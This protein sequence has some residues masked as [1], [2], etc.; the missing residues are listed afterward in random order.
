MS[1]LDED[2]DPIRGEH[3]SPQINSWRNGQIHTSGSPGYLKMAQKAQNSASSASIRNV[4]PIY[5]DLRNDVPSNVHGS[6]NTNK[7]E[8]SSKQPHF[9]MNSAAYGPPVNRP[10]NSAWSDRVPPNVVPRKST[11][12]SA[13]AGP[14]KPT[15]YASS[16]ITTGQSLV[17]DPHRG[18]SSK[19]PERQ[20]SS[21]QPVKASSLK[22]SPPHLRDLQTS[23]AASSAD[24]IDDIR[25]ETAKMNAGAASKSAKSDSKFPCTY[26]ECTRGF[27][28]KK[29]M[30]NH[31]E[32]AHDYCRVCNEDHDS[33]DQLLEHKMKSDNHI[34]CG[35]CGQDFYS[36]AGRD[37]HYRQVSY[38]FW[39]CFTWLLTCSGTSH[40]AR[41]QLSRM[42]LG[43]C[44][45]RRPDSPHLQQ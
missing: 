22:A 23:N 39:I 42:R 25:E 1:L 40:R 38:M 19:F 15:S 8:Q 4:K 16:T 41:G 7:T 13:H 9:P 44:D 3:F 12:Q 31:K 18:S 17:S 2:L 28:S 27:M 6:H 37:K 43:L 34:C 20:S 29:A 36:E 21:A 11:H 35:V 14:S 24:A 33:Y 5:A 10:D 26:D 30:K 32:E 45:W